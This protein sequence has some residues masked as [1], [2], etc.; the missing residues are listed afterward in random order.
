MSQWRP[1]HEG[2]AEGWAVFIIL[3]QLT[4]E[5]CWVSNASEWVSFALLVSK[6]DLG[7]AF[8]NAMQEVPV[9]KGDGH[10]R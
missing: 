10:D 7:P 2:S 8:F 3:E 9:K 6:P 5:V 4:I 1:S